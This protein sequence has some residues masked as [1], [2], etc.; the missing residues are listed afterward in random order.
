MSKSKIKST[1]KNEVEV[2]NLRKE[3][4]NKSALRYFHFTLKM[5]LY[6]QT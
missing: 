2:L 1:D 4:E 5:A 3:E 6:A